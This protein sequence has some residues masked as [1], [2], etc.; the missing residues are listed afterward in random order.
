MNS[1]SLKWIVEEDDEV[2]A[3]EWMG[4]DEKTHKCSSQ[5][6]SIHY[7]FAFKDASAAVVEYGTDVEDDDTRESESGGRIHHELKHSSIG[8]HRKLNHSN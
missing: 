3:R 2:E 5:T 1:P 6:S 7:K 8:F 4:W